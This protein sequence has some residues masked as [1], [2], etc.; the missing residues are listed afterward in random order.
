MSSL[1]RTIPLVDP[2][3]NEKNDPTIVTLPGVAGIFFEIFNGVTP[4]GDGFNDYFQIDGIDQFPNNNVQI[5]NR[6]GILIFEANGY[7]ESS[8]IFTGESNAR[9]NIGGDRLVKKLRH[10]LKFLLHSLPHNLNL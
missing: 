10:S 8:N 5:F 7:N 1:A 6:W 4:N 3:T 9:A 2:S